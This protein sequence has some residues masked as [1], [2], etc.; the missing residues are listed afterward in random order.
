MEKKTKKLIEKLTELLKHDPW[1]AHLTLSLLENMTRI[2]DGAVNK[3]KQS[4]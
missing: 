1:S 3:L 2:P 4:T